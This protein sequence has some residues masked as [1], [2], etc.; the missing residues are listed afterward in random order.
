MN[1]GRK[2]LGS[3]ESFSDASIKSGKEQKNRSESAQRRVLKVTQQGCDFIL[4]LV[5]NMVESTQL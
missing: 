1:K 2:V 4:W 3:N 5:R